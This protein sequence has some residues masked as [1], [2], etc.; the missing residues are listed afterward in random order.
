VEYIKAGIGIKA[1]DASKYRSCFS[2][3]GIKLG[4]KRE[5]NAMFEGQIR[6]SVFCWIDQ[7]GFNP[8]DPTSA[9]LL[10]DFRSVEVE[11][12]ALAQLTIDHLPL[13]VQPT[14]WG[15]VSPLKYNMIALQSTSEIIPSRRNKSVFSLKILD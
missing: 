4:T 9:G 13:L 7:G 2:K 15:I 6:N 1:D 3:G 8:F 14:S 11:Q 5:M 10:E 12:V